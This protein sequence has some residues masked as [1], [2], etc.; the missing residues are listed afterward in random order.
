MKKWILITG[1]IIY[2]AFFLGGPGDSIPATG[3][4]SINSIPI[5]KTTLIQPPAQL[6]KQ[7]YIKASKPTS[8]DIPKK[9]TCNPNYS[10]CLKQDSGDYDCV[11]GSGNGPNYT[12]MVRV[13]GYD[14][15]G[16][17]RDRDGWG[18]E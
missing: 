10:G 11:G 12:G 2:S 17:D 6:P 3:S 18:C 1:I 8:D 9:S 4:N 7:D 14:E 16:L 15:Y 5:E 13:I